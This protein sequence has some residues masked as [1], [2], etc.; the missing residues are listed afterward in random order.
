MLL[1]N[2]NEEWI[3]MRKYEHGPRV[4]LKHGKRRSKIHISLL[5]DVYWTLQTALVNKWRKWQKVRRWIKSFT[6]TFCVAIKLCQ[7]IYT[8][9][10]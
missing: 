4:T 6:S 9:Q 10:V 2:K 3:I 8:S 1:S 5:K 7:S